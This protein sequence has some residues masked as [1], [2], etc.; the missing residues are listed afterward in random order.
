MCQHSELSFIFLTLRESLNFFFTLPQVILIE[1]AFLEENENW[2]KALVKRT[3]LK[4]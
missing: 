1:S 2:I 3:I 4:N